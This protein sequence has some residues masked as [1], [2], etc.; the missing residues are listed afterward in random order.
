MKRIL[1]AHV[2]CVLTCMPILCGASAAS[3]SAPDAPGRPVMVAAAAIGYGG[4]YAQKRLLAMEYLHAAGK[5]G[6][7]IVCLPE[8]FCGSTPEPVPGPVTTEVGALAREYG[9]YVICPIREAAGDHLFNTA[10]LLDREGKIAGRYRKVYPFWSENVHAG[11]AT[12]PYF[13]TDFGR[14]G[15]LTCFDI[16]FPELWTQAERNG[17]EILFWPSAFGG[18]FPLRGYAGIHAYYV[19]SVGDGDFIDMT[20]EDI[21]PEARPLDHLFLATLDLDRTLVHKDYTREKVAELVSAYPEA[22]VLERDWHPEGWFMLRAVKPGVRVRDLCRRHDIETLREYRRRSRE[23]IDIRRDN[24]LPVGADAQGAPRH[25]D[26]DP[27]PVARTWDVEPSPPW[28]QAFS[29]RIFDA[30]RHG[31]PM[32]QLSAAHPEAT[33]SEA[34]AVQREAVAW[35]F[36]GDAVAG[37]KAAGVASAEEDFPL[38]AVM[39]AYGLYRGPDAEGLVLSLG[40]GPPRHVETEIG[41]VFGAAVTAPLENVEALRERVEAVAAIV[42]VPGYPV[43]AFQPVTREDLVAWNI[44][45]KAMLVG[46]GHAPASVDVDAVEIS[47]THEDAVINTARGEMAHGGQ[48]AAL[49]RTVNHLIAAGYRLEPGH[50]ITNGALGKIVRAEAGRYRADFGPLGVLTFEM[51]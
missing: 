18:G 11:E 43:E 30:W 41:F 37:Y 40:D 27:A 4:D 48:W 49:L 36:A 38:I 44:N 16:N 17:T 14:I 12:V 46:P 15:I 28:V 10:V 29:R 8:E 31:L 9:M 2:L 34:Y 13:D 6:A 23:Q 50:V 21:V 19:V 32:P 42:E 3:S 26:H 25:T 45:A 33:L 7:D 22:I 39:P 24:T 47:L 20:G 35:M 51:E 5:A 1:H